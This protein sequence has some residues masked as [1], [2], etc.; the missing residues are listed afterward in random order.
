MSS[1]NGRLLVWLK[2]ECGFASFSRYFVDRDAINVRYALAMGIRDRVS[3]G[4]SSV[5]AARTAMDGRHGKC[6]QGNTERRGLQ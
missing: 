2:I 1:T 5:M 6:D 3:T 4:R